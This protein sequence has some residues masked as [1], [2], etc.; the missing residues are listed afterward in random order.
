MYAQCCSRAP[1]NKS[2]LGRNCC[3]FEIIICFDTI[4]VKSKLNVKYTFALVPRN[5]I[6]CEFDL[7][8]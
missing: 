2:S 8:E 6:Y 3:L 7:S 4:C 5:A 1:K